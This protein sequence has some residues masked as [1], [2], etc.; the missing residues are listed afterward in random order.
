V[1]HRFFRW[2]VQRRLITASPMR[3]MPRPQA[4]IRRKRVLDD[5]ELRLMWEAAGVDEGPIGAAMQLLVLTCARRAEISGLRWTEV[6]ANRILLRG[7]RTK[8]GEDHIIPLSSM[9]RDLINGIPRIRDCPFV[10][11]ATG[12]SP[13]VGWCHFKVRVDARMRADL[14]KLGR[15]LQPWRTHDLR[16]T[17]ATGLER[18]G[19]PL[20]VTEALLGHT[21]G[22]KAGIAGVYQLHDCAKEKREAV[23]KWAAHVASVVGGE[24]R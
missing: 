21:A 12:T 17:A 7:E 2:A 8:N 9:A 10:F 5:E 23:E 4:E 14:A 15:E 6:E 19:V 11:T 22:S 3:D 13:I 18:L 1:A 20:Q 16:R 24:G